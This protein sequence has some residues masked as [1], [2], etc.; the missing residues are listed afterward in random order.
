MS[1][2]KTIVS[3]SNRTNKR[4]AA[5]NAASLFSNSMKQFI[6]FIFL[7]TLLIVAEYYFLTE[8]FTQKRLFVV[9]GSLAIVLGCLY[10]LIRFFKR[11]VFSS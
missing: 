9:A 1:K 5:T 2:P 3:A 6:V 10:S 11:S 8:V 4:A 7:L